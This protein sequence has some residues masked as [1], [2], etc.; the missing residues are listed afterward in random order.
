MILLLARSKLGGSAAIRSYPSS[1]AAAQAQPRIRLFL[2]GDWQV[3]SVPT[4]VVHRRPLGFLA[5]L[6][7]LRHADALW[8]RF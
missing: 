6:R 8:A 3:D 1:F 5:Q 2:I 4:N 7:R